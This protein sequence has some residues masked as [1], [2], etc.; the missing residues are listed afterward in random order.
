MRPY[1]I[2]DRKKPRYQN[3]ITYGQRWKKNHRTR[4]V[5]KRSLGASIWIE[6][7]SL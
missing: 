3:E 2:A 7:T 6:S 4:G 5:E 1:Q